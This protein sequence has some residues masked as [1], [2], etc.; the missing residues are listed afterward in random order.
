MQSL[1]E[2]PFLVVTSTLY[3]CYCVLISVRRT[4]LFFSFYSSFHK[5]HTIS[6]LLFP[7]QLSFYLSIHSHHLQREPDRLV[8]SFL[9]SFV[10]LFP[11]PTSS[12]LRLFPLSPPSPAQPLSC[13]LYITVSSAHSVAI[14]LA[15]SLTPAHPGQPPQLTHTQTQLALLAHLRSHFCCP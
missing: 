8:F 7:L 5:S 10:S 9:S 2:L 6:L 11:N 4:D 1:Q 15:N 12:P 14:N 13:Y 3:F